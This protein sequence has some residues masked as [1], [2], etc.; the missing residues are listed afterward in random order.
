MQTLH[1]Q[2]FF[3]TTTVLDNHSG[4]HVSLIAPTCFNFFTSS[5]TVSTCVFADLLGLCFFSVTEGLTFN[6]CIVKVGSTFR[7]FVLTLGELLPNLPV[8]Y[9]S[10]FESAYQYKVKFTLQ[11]T[12]SRYLL[13]IGFR[14]LVNAIIA[15]LQLDL[16]ACS[17]GLWQPPSTVLLHS[18]RLTLLP[19]YPQ[20]EIWSSDAT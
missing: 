9:F 2:F 8:T 15:S 13:L 19:P 3:F 14:H 12:L 10:L 6:R 20:L 1:F 18:S 7:N 4:K 11:L 17:H 5:F 16:F